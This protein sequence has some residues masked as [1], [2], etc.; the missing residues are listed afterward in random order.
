[1]RKLPYL[2]ISFLFALTAQGQV[3]EKMLTAL[4]GGE[5]NG[6]LSSVVYDK[7]D[8]STI[9]S[10]G[11]AIFKMNSARQVAWSD[12]TPNTYFRKIIT[13]SNGDYIALGQTGNPAKSYVC[14][15]DR[16][17]G[18][19]IWQYKSPNSTSKS[20]YDAIE[21]RNGNIALVGNN[22]ALLAANGNTLWIQ[23]TTPATVFACISQLSNGRLI[24]ASNNKDNLILELDELTGSILSK[25]VYN[26]K[27]PV[28]VN[29]YQ[30]DSV[31]Y[32]A[33]GKFQVKN[34]IVYYGAGGTGD[35]FW[36]SYA[37]VFVYDE[38]SKALSGNLYYRTPYSADQISGCSFMVLGNNDILLI[39]AGC[40]C[41]LDYP[42]LHT[43]YS[44]ITNNTIVSD[45]NI[46]GSG[47]GGPYFYAID[48]IQPN[49]AVMVGYNSVY[50]NPFYPSSYSL[51]FYLPDGH[52]GSSMGC[53][54][55]SNTGLTLLSSSLNGS[56]AATNLISDTAL[57]ISSN[58]YAS[59]AFID[60]SLCS[61]TITWTGGTSGN[62][63][64]PSN[65]STGAV[66]QWD[67][68]VTIPAG[69]PYSAKVPDGITV[70]CRSITIQPGADV[71]AGTDAHIIVTH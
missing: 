44:R 59:Y 60:N 23:V 37:L 26:F 45:Y 21:T 54:M 63:K 38:T 4:N 30:T 14:R 20:F 47:Y 40:F 6:S 67:D 39:Q 71:T 28:S 48:S 57:D 15:I 70:F 51:I 64:D 43:S 17:N 42:I 34:N 2:L 62:W 11:N 53:G 8:S 5:L 18:N 1:M 58:S 3:H 50:T 35:N 49:Q 61:G 33:D 16:N 56:P 25:Q 32:F 22:I 66:P 65:W 55:T 12:S 19:I 24:I 7:M 31:K 68:N 27:I 69:T 36:G 52:A 41:V 13:C 46:G 9:Y 10:M 29:I